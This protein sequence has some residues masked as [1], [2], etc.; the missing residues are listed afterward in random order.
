MRPQAAWKMLSGSLMPHSFGGVRGDAQWSEAMLRAAEL[1]E[2]L[3]HPLLNAEGLPL[4][5]LAASAYQLAGYP[6]RAAGLLSV[7]G[8]SRPQ[9]GPLHSSATWR[10][11]AP[12]MRRRPLD[13]ITNLGPSASTLL[14]ECCFVKANARR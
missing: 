1:L 13:G 12:V 14:V 8:E 2:W 10:W 5:L 11:S 3:S 9:S 6:A 4:G 7:T